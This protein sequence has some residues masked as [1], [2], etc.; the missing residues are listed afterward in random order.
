MTRRLVPLLALALA[1][2]CVHHAGDAGLAPAQAATPPSAPP[3]GA[4]TILF[5]GVDLPAAGS[6]IGGHYGGATFDV[7]QATYQLSE[8][9]RARWTQLERDRGESLMRGAGYLV[10]SVGPSSSDAQQ[11]LGVQYGLTGRV[12]NFAVRSSGASEPLTIDAQVDISWELL[13]LGSGGAVFGRQ[14]HASAR[15][16]GTVELGF[17]QVVDNALA[18][19]LGDTLFVRALGMPR[20]QPDA[21]VSGPLTRRLPPGGATIDLMD[22]DLNP[23]ADA[24]MVERLSAGL[25]MLRG[26]G[27]R[28]GTAVV[29]TRDGLAIAVGRTARTT[30]QLRARLPSGVEA[31]VMLVRSNAG[32]DVALLQIACPQAC[33]TVDW[34]APDEVRVFT[35]AVTIGA[36]EADDQPATPVVGRVGGRWGMASGITLEGMGGQAGGGWPVASTSSGRVFALV[37]TRPGRQSVV[38]LAEVLRALNVRA[39]ASRRG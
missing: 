5:M 36:P 15:V 38:L 18:R 2:A 8:S 24:S 33:E 3:A 30:Q 14:V 21:R 27:G 32:L 31:P 20:Y 1:G 16:A 9:V 39:P 17:A 35:G 4:G 6:I 23:S 37:S 11:L 25:V 26:Q 12:T 10:R 29:L 34:D 13:D 19:L 28:L 7:R 22:D